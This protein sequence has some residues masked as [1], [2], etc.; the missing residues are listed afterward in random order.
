MTILLQQQPPLLTLQLLDARAFDPRLPL[1]ERY[2]LSVRLLHV[3][4]DLG[5]YGAQR[6]LGLLVNAFDEPDQTTAVMTIYSSPEAQAALQVPVLDVARRGRYDL[7]FLPR[8]IGQMRRW[9]PDVVHTHM[10]NGKYWGRIA[11]LA[12]GV[13]T[14]VHTEHNSEFGAPPVFRPINRLLAG[15][16]T[17]VIAF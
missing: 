3:I 9:R 10:H 4:A 7:A 13:P 1:P 16:T 2:C 17:A 5:T 15:R 11:A 6:M 14:I 12:C 8:M